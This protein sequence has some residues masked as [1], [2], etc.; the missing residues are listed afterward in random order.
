MKRSL[1]LSALIPALAVSGN[2][3]FTATLRASEE[4]LKLTTAVDRPLLH[5]GGGESKVV[6]KI[7]V[8]GCRAPQKAR[9]PLNLAIV[10]DRSG[11]MSGGK[12]EQ[13]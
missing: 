3:F 2:S 11:S 7:E 9:T 6:I 13:A 10:L 12:L 4:S 8:E 5:E 1:I